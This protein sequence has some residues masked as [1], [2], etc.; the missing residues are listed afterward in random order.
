LKPE[1]SQA[2]ARIAVPRDRVPLAAAWAWIDAQPAAPVRESVPLAQAAARRLADP[3]A[4]AADLPD[5]NRAA[6]DGYAVRAADC[7]GA[8]A[9]N[10]LPLMVQEA[11][12]LAR[13]AASLVGAGWPMPGG[14]DAVLPQEAAQPAG[15]WLEVLAPVAPG[16]GVARAGAIWRAGTMLLEAGRRLRPQDLACLAALG[17]TA[18]PVL[19]RPLVRLVVAG[20]KAG[21][22][23]LTPLLEA[24][25]ARDGAIADRAPDLAY[26]AAPDAIILAGRSGDGPD[27]T[28]AAGLQAAGGTLALHGVALRPG[29]T[30][31]LGAIGP[32]P[33]ILL[34][35]E[36]LACLAAYDMLAG[37]LIRRLGGAGAGLPYR[38][39]HA[40]LARKIV[41]GIGLTDIVPVRWQDGRI[42]PI[43]EAGVAAAVQADGFVMVA[44]GS[45]GY[46]AGA[47]VPVHLYEAADP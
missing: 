27:D 41:S 16:T 17:M 44:E 18:V 21:Y 33:V 34:P 37:R 23:V 19:R 11:G 38:T 6:A 32:V 45:E 22:D 4:S 31:G 12:P 36:P 13:G 26:A 3:V 47:T 42:Q 24:L 39:V 5:Q 14:A 29:E 10:P 46:P 20:P 7:D 28:A 1:I 15:S 25:L 9:Y 2:G 8:S 40:A 30:A 43:G 35:G